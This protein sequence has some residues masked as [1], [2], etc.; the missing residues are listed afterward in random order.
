[1][2]ALTRLTGTN[3]EDWVESLKLFLG[4]SNVVAKPTDTSSPAD[5][6]KHEKWVHSHKVC[7]MTMKYT[8]EKTVK[9]SIRDIENAKE[10]LTAVGEKYKKF[11]KA[12]KS[13][14]MSLLAKT[15]YD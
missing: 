14:Y 8:V 7:L 9:E 10:F 5:K 11:D 6:L 15:K 12:E 2:N 1:M 4:V 3:Y 13:K